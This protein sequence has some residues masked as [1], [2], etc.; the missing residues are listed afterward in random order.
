MTP[1]PARQAV[2]TSRLVALPVKSKPISAHQAK[3]KWLSRNLPFTTDLSCIGPDQLGK[4]DCHVSQ[5]PC[6]QP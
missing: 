4:K 5:L 2:N 6:H 1:Q 3:V